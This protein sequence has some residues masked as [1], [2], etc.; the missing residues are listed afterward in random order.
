MTGA[1]RDAQAS[2]ASLDATSSAPGQINASLPSPLQASGRFG[3]LTPDAPK[4]ERVAIPDANAK[5]Q[6]VLSFKDADVS[7]VVRQV[8]GEHLGLNY[9]LDPKVEGRV[10]LHF[11]GKISK[12]DLLRLLSQALRVS[13]I[14]T[15]DQNGVLVI[16]PVADSAGIPLANV[17][18]LDGT[19]DAGATIIAYR[20]R[21]VKAAQVLNVVKPF[22]TSGRPLMAD[23]GTNSLVFADTAA[24]A[25]TALNLIRS[26][27]I[28]LLGEMGMEIVPLKGLSPEDAAKSLE[29]LLGKIGGLKGSV[30]R[31]SL[32]FMPLEQYQGLLVFAQDQHVLDIARKWLTALDAQGQEMGEQV[33][34]YPVENGLAKDITEIL[35]KVYGLDS[36]ASDDGLTRELVAAVGTDSVAV[37]S[38]GGIDTRFSGNVFIIP[39]EVNNFIVVRANPVDYEKVQRAIAALDKLP[40]AVL[41]EVIIAEVRLTDQF[42]YGVEWFLRSNRSVINGKTF[43]NRGSFDTGVGYST[44]AGLGGS[45][46]SSI[47]EG[48]AYFIGASDFQ[49]LLHLLDEDNKLNVLSTPTLLALDNTEASI[50]IGGKEPILSQSQ[51]TGD[52]GIINTVQYQ[53]TGIILNVTPHINSSGLV[54]L[55]VEQEIRSVNSEQVASVSLNTP[56]FTERTI[57]TSL[58]AEDGKTV[59][60]GGI[61]ESEK[62]VIR[63]AVPVLGDIPVL[64]FLFSKKDDTLEK[65]ELLVAITPHVIKR[66][67]DQFAQKLL[68]RLSDLKRRINEATGEQKAAEGEIGDEAVPVG[69]NGQ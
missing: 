9:V 45:A 57:K 20:L 25:R 66:E 32:A 51:S 69:E 26:L 28:D 10:N 37:S 30:S 29:T 46:S 52:T 34:V 12:E 55:E 22:L 67:R 6:L 4:A 11:E 53:D 49:V 8:V 16:R 24:N 39:D 61:I 50:T 2:G 48:F 43:Q 23:E 44:S 17:H 56:R 68:D 64:G 40:R 18:A 13:G 15:V 35:T 42:V 59:V 54:R 36:G 38:S 19:D 21:H 7:E 63:T 14:D 65:K 47:P 27:D 5:D 58:V 31:E 62:T 41:I 3:L 60:I 1:A 33:F